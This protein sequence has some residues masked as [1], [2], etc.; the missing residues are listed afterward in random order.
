MAVTRNA[1][2][3]APVR[4]A[5]ALTVWA[6][7]HVSTSIGSLGRL[8][9]QP[10]ASLMIMLVIAVTLALPAAV[11]LVVKNA[12]LVSSGWDNALDFS[13]FLNQEVALPEAQGLAE[14]IAQR[15]DVANVELVAADD[16]LADFKRQSGFGEALDQLGIVP[17][18]ATQIGREEIVIGLHR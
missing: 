15:A 16:A 13:V 10:F 11:G 17:I 18:Q 6:T 1:D 3:V 2:A 12:Q 8:L 9:R 4:T 14:L 7:R 5:G